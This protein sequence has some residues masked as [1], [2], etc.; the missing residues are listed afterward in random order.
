M[1]ARAK[2]PLAELAARAYDKVASAFS[3]VVKKTERGPPPS[4]CALRAP[5]NAALDIKSVT[6]VALKRHACP[7]PRARRVRWPATPSPSKGARAA[8]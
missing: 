3:L 8:P 5:A 6:G 7:P 4:T 2:P 1:R